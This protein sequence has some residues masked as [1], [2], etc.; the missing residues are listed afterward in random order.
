MKTL[1]LTEVLDMISQYCENHKGKN[2]MML[3]FHSNSDLDA[4]KQIINNT[5]SYSTFI[6]H[7]LKLGHTSMVLNGETVKIAAHPEL[8][9]KFIFPTT[10]N[11]ST[12][13]FVYH[14]YI[15]QLDA[16]ALQYCVDIVN[17]GKYPVVCLM[18]DYSLQNDRPTEGLLSFMNEYF[19]QYE[20]KL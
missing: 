11:D 8:V 10:K 20:I 5:P 13:L 12:R 7:P 9:E 18:N 2:P 17:L 3:W 6:G 16:E 1:K 14:K 4:V 15:Q 19:D